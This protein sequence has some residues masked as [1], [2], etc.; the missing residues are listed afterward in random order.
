VTH[1]ELWRG[2]DTLAAEKGLSPSGL[3]KAA[4]LDPTSFNRSKRCT[5]T[6]PRWP[7]T[8]S[9]SRVLAATGTSLESFAVLVAGARVLPSSN[10]LSG[11]MLPWLDLSRIGWPGSFDETGC[12]VGKE[13]SRADLPRPDDPN[14]YAVRV[15]GDQLDPVFRC[16]SM[17]V[18]APGASPGQGD[19]VV[20]YAGARVEVCVVRQDGDGGLTLEPI[21]QA[22]SP[23]SWWDRAHRIVWASS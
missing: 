3:A 12:P 17:L 4:G 9:L 14:G 1:E 21:D 15:D 19:R 20:G 11:R 8:E 18:I 23:M 5:A 13:W 16:K 10:A 2:I 22:A 6:G 7:G